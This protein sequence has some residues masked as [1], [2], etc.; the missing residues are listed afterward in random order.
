V[1]LKGYDVKLSRLLSDIQARDERDSNRSV[2][3]LVAA[4][5]A[6][7]LDS[8]SMGIKQVLDK[9]KYFIE[10]KLFGDDV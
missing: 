9:A 5:D 2:A 7:V 3:P 8:T 10:S 6:L 1:K 4:S